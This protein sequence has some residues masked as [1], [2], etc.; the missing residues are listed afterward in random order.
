MRESLMANV[1]FSV[2]ERCLLESQS[3]APVDSRCG[4]GLEIEPQGAGVRSR[5]GA[6]DA[7]DV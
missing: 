4:E 1:A 7:G 6:P 2:A 5:D 3:H